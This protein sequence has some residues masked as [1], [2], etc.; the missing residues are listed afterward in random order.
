LAVFVVGQDQ[1]PAQS[2]LPSTIMPEG[3]SAMK[4]ILPFAAT[5]LGRAAVLA[6]ATPQPAQAAACVNGVYRAGCTGRTGLLSCAS[7]YHYRH[8]APSPVPTAFT[9]PDVPGQMGPL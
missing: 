6:L 8:K 2:C 1:T 5:V 3:V 9:A 4:P 7:D